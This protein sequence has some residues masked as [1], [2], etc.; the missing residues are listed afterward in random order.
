MIK[1]HL[2]ILLH[3]LS[4]LRTL[5]TLHKY[6]KECHILFN[7]KVMIHKIMFNI[8]YWPLGLTPTSS[9]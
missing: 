9:T 3:E 8:N 4:I 5:L 1:S 6:N 2:I 7:N